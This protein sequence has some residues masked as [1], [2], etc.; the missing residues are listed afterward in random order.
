[1][2]ADIMVTM[3][4][5]R[6]AGLP[7]RRPLCAPSIRTWFA[8]HGFIFRDFLLHGI[9]L[10]VAETITDEFCVRACALARAEHEASHGR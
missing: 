2:T 8:R 9:P 10:R 3:R 6:A 7:G 1:M 5:V 4:H